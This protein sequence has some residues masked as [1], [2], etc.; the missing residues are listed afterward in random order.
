MKKTLLAIAVGTLIAGSAFAN[1]VNKKGVYVGADVGVSDN[2]KALGDI[3]VGYD[4]GNIRGEISQGKYEADHDSFTSTMTVE[5]PKITPPMPGIPVRPGIK[6]PMPV[7]PV[8]PDFGNG[9]DGWEKPSV[10]PPM[11]VL[12]TL[13]DFGQPEDP[14]VTPPMP[15]LPVLPTVPPSG[16][17]KNPIKPIEITPPTPV[18]PTLPDFEGGGSTNNPIYWKKEIEK[19]YNDANRVAKEK[20]EAFEKAANEHDKISRDPNATDEEKAAAEKKSD[21]AFKDFL[22]ASEK[23]RNAKEN[24]DKVKDLN[25]KISP[26]MDAK[27]NDVDNPIKDWDTVSKQLAMDVKYKVD[28]D[29]TMATMYYDFHNDSKFTPYVMGGLGL[30]HNSVTAQLNEHGFTGTEVS[31]SKNQLAWQVGVGLGYSITSNLTA[32][33]MVKYSDRGKL[34]LNDQMDVSYEGAY[35]GKMDVNHDLKLTST[36]VTIGLRYMF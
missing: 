7:L 14:K 36:D 16:N 33:V 26:F 21:D 9:S 11:P 18:I 17:V 3:K 10:N 6:P 22:E 32:D 27:N 4:F 5:V 20:Q 23:A 2:G 31:K 29:V 1:D 25:G 19:V 8:L 34:S 35:V 12:P 30:A 28:S 13:P 24:W 15:V